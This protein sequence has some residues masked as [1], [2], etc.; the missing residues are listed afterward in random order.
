MK[1]GFCVFYMHPYWKTSL[2]LLIARRHATAFNFDE[3][4]SSLILKHLL[5]IHTLNIII[6]S[7]GHFVCAHYRNDA[8]RAG[9]LS[10]SSQED[11][12][13]Y[14]QNDKVADIFCNVCADE[15]SGCIVWWWLWCVTLR[16]QNVYIYSLSEIKLYIYILCCDF[17][18]STLRISY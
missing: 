7:Y 2:F 6:N 16:V 3:I 17:Y 8:T 14:T 9:R 15:S 5:H 12:N 13:F 11:Q 10:H 18:L 4:L 1:T